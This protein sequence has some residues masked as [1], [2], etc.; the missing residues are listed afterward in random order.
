M[1]ANEW[2]GNTVQYR[3]VEP[4]FRLHLWQ[5]GTIYRRVDWSSRIRRVLT[6]N[7][8]ELLLSEPRHTRWQ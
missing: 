3:R 8:A 5:H 6:H 2:R 1:T 7:D 4:S